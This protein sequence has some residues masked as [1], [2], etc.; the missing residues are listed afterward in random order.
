MNGKKIAIIIL[1]FSLLAII[2]SVILSI[3]SINQ[4]GEGYD[5][6]NEAIFVG[7]D[8]SID[9]DTYVSYSV[10]VKSD[11]SC[12]DVSLSIY[13]G[14]WEYFYQDCDN[15]MNEDGWNYIGY[16]VSDIDGTMTVDSNYQVAIVNDMVF[17]ESGV[18]AMLFS[19]AMCCLGIIG[20]IISIIILLT[21]K[22]K[23]LQQQV[24]IVNQTQEIDTELG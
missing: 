2:G 9:V 10:Y 5:V 7:I 23:K 13:Q 15:I 6:D 1:G 11:Y 12:E 20:I 21:T 14:D 22:D 17:L 4:I 24:I 8:G 18:Y 3:F 16:F 19:G